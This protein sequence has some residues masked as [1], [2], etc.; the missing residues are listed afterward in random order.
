[1]V[2]PLLEE[3]RLVTLC[4]HEY[5]NFVCQL[6]VK[7]AEMKGFKDKFCK[8]LLGIDTQLETQAKTEKDLD[9]M[10]LCRNKFGSRVVQCF[11]ENA[12]EPYVKILLQTLLEEQPVYDLKSFGA[13]F[14]NVFEDGSDGDIAELDDGTKLGQISLPK[15]GDFGRFIVGAIL[16]RIGEAKSQQLVDLCKHRVGQELVLRVAG[17]SDKE[18]SASANPIWVKSFL[19]TLTKDVIANISKFEDRTGRRAPAKSGAFFLAEM[20]KPMM[21]LINAKPKDGES[22]KGKK[23]DADEKKEEAARASIRIIDEM[24]QHSVAV[25]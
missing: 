2:E 13:A 10:D 5:A 9:V 8:R 24:L 25:Q 12:D 3:R 20:R 6:F 16:K 15:H 14:A 1:M 17:L 18:Q 23:K 22:K 11:V 4:K 19:E 21:A 7:L